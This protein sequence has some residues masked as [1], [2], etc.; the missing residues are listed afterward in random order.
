MKILCCGDRH[1]SNKE[2]IREVLQ[3]YPKDTIL[4]EG[5]AYGADKLC[6]EVGIDLGMT[7]IPVPANWIKYGKAA[8]PIRNKEMLDMKPEEVVCFHDNIALSKG[9]KNCLSQ[10]RMYGIRSIVITN[11][12]LH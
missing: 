8:G 5:E 7:I 6:K 4:I 1:W 9:S 2:R 12:V 3:G 11:K 10:A